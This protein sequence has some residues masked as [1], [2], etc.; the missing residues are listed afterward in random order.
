MTQTSTSA[1]FLAAVPALEEQIERAAAA[2]GRVTDAG[3]DTAPIRETLLRVVGLRAE[4]LRPTHPDAAVYARANATVLLL[5]HGPAA[6]VAQYGTRSVEPAA[7]RARAASCTRSVC[8][9]ATHRH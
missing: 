1:A 2:Y 7:E 4:Y 9:D 6:V 5:D 3:G 8:L